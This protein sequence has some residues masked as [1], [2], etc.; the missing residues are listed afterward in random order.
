M[1]KD[2]AFS[3]RSG[4]GGLRNGLD[5]GKPTLHPWRVDITRGP[6][7]IAWRD[8]VLSHSA[9]QS[10]LE[11]LTSYALCGMTQGDDSSQSPP[12]KF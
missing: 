11:F 12:S 10:L 6:Q 1:R 7:R 4:L 5:C 2:W 8:S 9:Q 3:P